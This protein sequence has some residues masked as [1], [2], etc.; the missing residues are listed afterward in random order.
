MHR[1]WLISRLTIL[2]AILCLGCDTSTAQANVESRAASVLFQQFETV[3][4][5]PADFLSS[6]PGSYRGISDKEIN[7][8][9]G[10]PVFWYLLGGLEGL[11]K[12][13]SS[14]ILK[15]SS[16]VLMGAKNFRG[17]ERGIGPVRSQV[18]YVVLLSNENRVDFRKYFRTAP[19]KPTAGRQIFEWSTKMGEFGDENPEKPTSLYATQVG[20]IFLLVSNRKEDVSSVAQALESSKENTESFSNVREWEKVSQHQFWGYRLYRHAAL[21]DRDRHAAGMTD[22]TASAKALIFLVDFERKICAVRLL[23]APNGGRTA[24]NINALNVLPRFKLLEPGVWQSRYL[25]GDE[26]TEERTLFVMSLF[27]FGMYF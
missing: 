20:S 18:C 7:I 3:F 14:E 22:V 13:V 2:G 4:R 27:G 16:A 19:E 17:P 8:I 9:R 24:V 25:F 10:S 15:S 23:T 6:Y 11:G 5:A 1:A 26:Y 12:G 21:S